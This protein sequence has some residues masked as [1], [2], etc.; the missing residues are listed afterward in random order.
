M[1][2][3]PDEKQILL[4]ELKSKRLSLYKESH[5]IHDKIFVKAKELQNKYKDYYDYELFHL[6]IGSTLPKPVPNFDFPGE[7]SIVDFLRSL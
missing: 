7:D 5:D 6:L 4:E 3:A 1:E 2:G